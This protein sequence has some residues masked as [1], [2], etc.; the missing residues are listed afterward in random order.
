MLDSV[1]PLLSSF[2]FLQ[3]S[4][5]IG[6]EVGEDGK[7]IEVDDEGGVEQ[8]K[9]AT[10]SDDNGKLSDEDDRGSEEED[11]DSEEED[12]DSEE[13]DEGSEVSVEKEEM[14]KVREE[15]GE[16]EEKVRQLKIEKEPRGSRG[17]DKEGDDIEVSEVDEVSEEEEEVRE[18]RVEKKEI[19]KVREDE[20]KVTEDKDDV[21]EEK[22]VVREVRVHIKDIGK[23]MEKEG[24]VIEVSDEEDEGQVIELSENED[25]G[26]DEEDDGK[27]IELSENEDEASDEEDDGK[28]IELSENED[29]ASD[30]ED[31]GKV[32]ELSENEDAGSDEEDDDKV[33]ELSENEDEASD[34]EDDDKVIE[35]SEKEDAA[36]D[37]EDEG[38]VIEGSEEEVCIMKE[39]KEE[40]EKSKV[41]V[42]RG[43]VELTEVGEE[44]SPKK[45]ASKI[46]TP[47]R[48]SPRKH[49]SHGQSP[50]DS[51][52]KRL[53]L[54]SPAATPPRAAHEKLGRVAQLV[55]EEVLPVRR[56]RRLSASST[57]S[58]DPQEGG[59]LL[60]SPHATKTHSRASHQSPKRHRICLID[61]DIDVPIE[62]MK[63]PTTAIQSSPKQGR[64]PGT[65][66]TTADSP[67]SLRGKSAEL[68]PC[69]DSQREVS[70]TTKMRTPRGKTK[71]PVVQ[72][73]YVYKC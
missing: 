43:E 16:D 11:G 54:H 2:V 21:S 33:I 55:F 73:E 9:M 25:A 15:E 38:Q 27:V 17:R 8:D 65:P 30:E 47:Q 48:G 64:P 26:S 31:D 10:V 35:L 56:S 46:L 28:V 39:N 6:Y 62:T 72:V 52:A 1:Q 13:E 36:S 71:T 51:P 40:E 34:E 22:E 20:G 45:L 4:K 70:S 14:G 19:G 42:K 29:E 61:D 69:D 12:G 44:R 18:V 3:N 63:M 23:V 37:E 32:I 66:K 58:N 59:V 67:Y 7:M 68:A 50:K 24:K 49:L 53:R 41:G 57:L 5:Q 60:G